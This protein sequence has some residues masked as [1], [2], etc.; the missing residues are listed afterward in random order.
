MKRILTLVLGVLINC[1]AFAAGGRNVV[2]FVA[3]GLRPGSVNV[4]DAPTMFGIRQSGVFFSNSHALF[5]TFTTPNASAIATGHYLGDTGDFS[6]TVYIGYPVFNTGNFGKSAAS[7]A[8][9]LEDDQILCD[10]NDHYNGNYLNEESLLHL[11][12]QYGY[13]TAA[14]GKLGPTAIQEVGQV[15]PVNKNFAMPAPEGIIIDDSTGSD[16]GVPLDPA[17]AAA[18]AQAGLGTKPVPRKQPAGNNT[19]HGTLNANVGQQQW[20]A[21]AVTKAILPAF[22]ASGKPFAL[23]F[24]SRDPDGT[25][26]NQGD[27]LNS[28]TPGINGPT[29][30][31]AVKNADD[32]LKQILDYINNDPALA[33]NTDIFVTSDHGFATISRHE[34]DAAGHA[35]SSYAAKFTYKNQTGRVEVQPGFLPPG[36][37]AIDLAH[38]LGMPLYDPG[39]L[40]DDGNGGKKYEPVDPTI[41]QQ[42]ATTRQRPDGGNGLIGASGKIMDQTDAKVIVAANGGSDLIYVPD[43]DAQRVRAIVDFLTK[44]DYVGALFVD[45][46]FGKIPGALP[47]SS[48]RLKGATP[49]P[50]P[51]VAVG[52]RTFPLDAAVPLMTAVQIADTTLQEGQGMHGSIGRDNTFNNMAAMG[53]DF[54]K[55][56]VDQAPV[57][58]ADITPTIAH[59]LG[60]KLP[61]KGTM[62]GRV[63]S[64]ALKGGPGS[65]PFARKTLQ[66]DKANG[67]STVMFYQ[68]LHTQVYFDEACLIPAQAGANPA[69]CN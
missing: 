37:L 46:R 15:R 29:S 4:T 67:R 12:R 23:V 31:A 2:I 66:S 16:S 25:Q 24:W 65:V 49:M 13:R 34:I 30:R 60:F 14:V 5:P 61:R 40:I 32:N 28:L 38:T 59:L 26:H 20:F 27:S 69:S 10:V 22:K 19:D 21:D 56:Y 62:Q 36:F 57:S 33:A 42:T 48:I 63:L 64:E 1:S 58:N 18:L 6:N 17:I 55:G 41:P 43:N 9:F 45:D 35:T 3:D 52:F 54:K 8:P 50:V 51:A 11:A 68:R 39:S 44:Q 47:L 7:P 53:P